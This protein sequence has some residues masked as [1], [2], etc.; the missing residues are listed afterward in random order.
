LGREIILNLVR[1]IATLASVSPLLAQYG[2]PAILARGQSPASMSATHIDFR[3]YLTLN[4][5]YDSGLNGVAV[6]S[7]GALVNDASYGVSVGFGISGFHSWKHTRVGLDYSGGFSHYSRTFY[8]GFSGQSFNLSISHQLSRHA[9]VSLNNSAGLYGSNRTA[10]S[11]PQTVDFDPTTTYVPTND[12]FDNRTI[13]LSSQA[14]L[15]VQRSTRLSLS[16]GGDGFM[17]RRRSTA[18]Y[19]VTGIGAHGDVQYRITRR[20]TVG[21]IYQ[22]MH[23]GFTR[24]FSSTDSHAIAASYSL[25]ISRSTQVSA[26]GGVSRYETIFVQTVAIDPAIAALIGISSAQRVAYQKNYAPN[27][28]FRFA[29]TVPRGTIFVNASHLLIPGNGL[30]LTSTSTNVGLGYNYVGLRRWAISAGG[31]YDRSNSV[32]NVIGEYG[33]YSVNLSLSR[34]VAPSTHGVF[35]FNARR[36]Q[37]GDFNNYYKWAYGVRL[38]LSFSPG[39]IPLRLW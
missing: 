26:F 29:K 3:P 22:Y 31:N 36:Y 17:T 33:G 9:M 23:Y 19:G 37:S 1:A 11:L 38:G 34:Q 13:S 25:A 7:N 8:D 14:S 4:G 2:G 28:A 12:F 21:A 32:G 20:S 5:S 24:I 30:F 27:V 35:S 10:P 6:D 16:M 18:L 15:T 39:D